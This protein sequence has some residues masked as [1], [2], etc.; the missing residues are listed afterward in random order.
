MRYHIKIQGKIHVG[1]LLCG[2]CFSLPPAPCEGKESVRA[3]HGKIAVSLSLTIEIGIGNILT[4]AT[5]SPG[6]RK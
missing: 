4:L 2:V 1:F 5:F 6:P 3:R